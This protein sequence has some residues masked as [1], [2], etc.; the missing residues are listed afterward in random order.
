[1]LGL[2]D[3]TKH[4]FFKSILDRQELSPK[5]LAIHTL[6]QCSFI[7]HSY[8]LDFH[9]ISAHQ[10]LITDIND[11]CTCWSGADEEVLDG[12]ELTYPE[13]E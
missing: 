3:I 8:S 4:T 11:G 12:V 6:N 10:S 13:I 2:R 7:M 9:S 5:E 1:M